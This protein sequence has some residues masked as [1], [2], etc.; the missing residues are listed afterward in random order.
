ML[1]LGTVVFM[2]EANAQAIS[3]PGIFGTIGGGRILSTGGFSTAVNPAIGFSGNA[4]GVPTNLND[5]NGGNGIFRP[6]NNTMAFSTFS[7]ERMR[8]NA[9]GNIGIATTVAPLAKLHIETTFGVTPLYVKANNSVAAK[10]V[11]VGAGNPS[12]EIADPCGDVGIIIKKDLGR[13]DIRFTGSGLLFTASGA[14]QGCSQPS[15]NGM[16]LTGQGKL[17]IGNVTSPGNYKLYVQD[18]ILAEKVRVASPGDV[19]Y[20]PD[21]VFSDE[22]KLL[23]LTELEKY[24]QSTH[25]LPNVPSA[26]VVSTEG[27]DMADMFKAQMQKI[28]ELSLYVIQLNK[29]IET[30]KKA[31]AETKS[32]QK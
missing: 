10:F 18:G 31:N 30:L 4:V 27:I 22:Y 20:W 23:S 24:I 21:Y 15:G 7:T 13:A 14:S 28:E 1:F 29:E 16:E 9:N 26:T 25:H 17:V 3:S 12:V 32:E 2:Q 6:A 19:T 8:I 11:T 5:V